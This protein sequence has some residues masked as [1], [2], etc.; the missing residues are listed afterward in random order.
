M[1]W[2]FDNLL[3]DTAGAAPE[4]FRRAP[5]ATRKLLIAL[6]GSALLTWW[7]WVK[8]HPPEIVI[9]AVIHFVFMLALM[10]LVIF[11]RQRLSRKQAR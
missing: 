1:H 8:H 9:A 3:W 2:I 6:A 5:W 4:G 7:E 10:A 11:A